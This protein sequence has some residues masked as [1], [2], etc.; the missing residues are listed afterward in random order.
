MVAALV[1]I[2]RLPAQ[3]RLFNFEEPGIPGTA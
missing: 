3:T 1:L 2:G